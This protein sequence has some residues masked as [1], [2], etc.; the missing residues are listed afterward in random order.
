MLH[1]YKESSSVGGGIRDDQ[2]DN[3]NTREGTIVVRDPEFEIVMTDDDLDN[4]KNWSTWYRFWVIGTI[5]FSAW[6]VVLYS[7]SYMSCV[8]GLK[9]DFGTTNLEVTMGMTTYLTGLAM[10]SLFVA[11]LSEL[12]GRRIAYLSSIC[13]WTIFIIPCG[14]AQSFSTILA[15]RFFG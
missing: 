13:A 14:L 4:P 11:P 3:T 6:V 2:T 1:E 15:S 5:S 7:T 12:Y 8:P 9:S 10:A